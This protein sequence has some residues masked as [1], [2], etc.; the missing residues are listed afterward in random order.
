[1]D[2]LRN[3]LTL[4]RSMSHEFEIK[5]TDNFTHFFLDKTSVSNNSVLI[6]AAAN[7]F[8]TTHEDLFCSKLSA[9]GFRKTYHKTNSDNRKYCNASHDL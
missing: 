1:M 5:Y 4:C 3:A 7:A 6:A 8:Y 2:M 9:Q